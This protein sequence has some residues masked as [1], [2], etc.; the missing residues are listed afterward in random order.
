MEIKKYILMFLKVFVAI[1]V[2][3]IACAL[4]MEARLYINCGFSSLCSKKLDCL[5]DGGS[6]D[7]E[8]NVCLH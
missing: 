6:W 1:I 5:D 2:F 8:H 4:L 3:I 7:K